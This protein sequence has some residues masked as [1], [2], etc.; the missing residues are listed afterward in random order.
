MKIRMPNGMDVH[1]HSRGE[2][3]LLFDEIF[4]KKVYL[5]HGIELGDGDVVFDVGANL[6]LFSLFLGQT[7]Q[8]FTLYAFE[9][10]PETFASLRSNTSRLAGKVV[11]YNVGLSDREGQAVFTYYP[12]LASFT[13]SCPD[14][15]SKRWADLKDIL[16]GTDDSQPGSS[17]CG[18]RWPGETLRSWCVRGLIYYASRK[19]DRVCRLTRL[20]NIVSERRIERIDL[21]KIDVEG[22]EWEVLRGI[23]ETDWGKIQ[24]VVV[25]VHDAAD[26]VEGMSEWLERRGYEVTVDSEN[27]DRRSPLFMLYARRRRGGGWE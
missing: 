12:R 7:M 16:M 11:L 3:R 13:T 27:E 23:E 8:D 17:R 1:G 14:R 18:W 19:Q 20:S 10:I 25:E 21:L 22:S 24:Q 9:P 26:G 6:G 5:K 15:L 4:N 2:A